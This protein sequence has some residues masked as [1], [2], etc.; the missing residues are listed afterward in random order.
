V[1]EAIKA[2]LD[3][4]EAA[5]RRE[6]EKDATIIRLT[7]ERD[8]AVKIIRDARVYLDELGSPQYCLYQLMKWPCAENGGE[9][10]DH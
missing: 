10:D 8:T 5:M 2:A 9:K 1:R 7:A 4:L 6:A 3:A